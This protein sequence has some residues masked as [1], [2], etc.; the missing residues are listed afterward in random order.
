MAIK[1][2]WT[3]Q[4]KTLEANSNFHNKV[5]DILASDSFFSGL[6]CYQE[7]PVVDLNPDYP[8]PQHRFDWYIEEL[9]TVVELHGEQ[10]YRPVSYGTQSYEK[11]QSDF[12]A[13]QRRDEDKRQAALAVGLKYVIIPYRQYAKLDGALLKSLII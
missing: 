3:N 6:S 11:T 1:S 12:K 10:H 13:M 2:R 4:F 7:V 8:N 9:A 5:R